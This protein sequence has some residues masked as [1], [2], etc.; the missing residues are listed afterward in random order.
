[1]PPTIDISLTSLITGYLLTMLNDVLGF[2]VSK[3]RKIYQTL[4]T[5]SERFSC[6]FKK[7]PYNIKTFSSSSFFMWSI[8]THRGKKFEESRR[9]SKRMQLSYSKTLKAHTTCLVLP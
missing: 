8:Q 4:E 5:V 6:M 3:S 7:N 2:W 9:E 1:V